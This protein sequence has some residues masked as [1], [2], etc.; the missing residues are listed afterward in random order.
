[1]IS[2]TVATATLT[3]QNIPALRLVTSPRVPRQIAKAMVF[4][5]VLTIF[6]ILFLPWQ[7]SVGGIGQVVAYAPLERQQTI[8]ANISG[9][10]FQWG[11]GIREGVQVKKGQAVLEIRDIDPQAL[12]RYEQQ[13]TAARQKLS[14][15][16][17]VAAAY[18][19]K[20]R[21]V[22]E[23]QLMAIAAAKQEV[24]MAA[25]KVA[26]EQQGLIAVEAARTQ[27]SAF[28]TRKRQLLAEQLTSPQEVEIADR[29]FSEEVAK[30][31]QAEAYVAS[32]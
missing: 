10:V 21:A 2:P 17:A 27:A 8:Q 19:A 24:E 7:Q 25:Q 3:S 26:A 5:L 6:A 9:R 30:T 14:A 4:A 29:K 15:Y 28:L 16:T 12:E 32:A 11:D 23:G 13:R 31:K 20:L 22:T 1:M 18:E